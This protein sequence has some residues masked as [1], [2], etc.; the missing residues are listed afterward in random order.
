MND[1]PTPRDVCD[2][3]RAASSEAALAEAWIGSRVR[4]LEMSLIQRVWAIESWID[5][6]SK[7]G[8]DG[9]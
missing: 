8:D 5:A 6:Q 7:L 3:I 2:A 4:R 9:K 1:A